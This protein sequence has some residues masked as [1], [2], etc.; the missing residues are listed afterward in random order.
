MTSARTALLGGGALVGA[1]ALAYARWEAA[2]YRLR[3][4]EVPV[5]PAGR[6]A[7]L[8]LGYTIGNGK[9]GFILLDPSDDPRWDV[10]Y[11]FATAVCPD[12]DTL[13]SNLKELAEDLQ[14]DTPSV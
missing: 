13:A 4:L 6:S 2:S 3:T 12:L 14:I 8:E 5:L 11:Q 1:A 7:H 9:S 10:M